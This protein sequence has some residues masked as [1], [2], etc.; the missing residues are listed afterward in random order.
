MHSN[1]APGHLEENEFKLRRWTELIMNSASVLNGKSG[2]QNCGYF[3]GERSLNPGWRNPNVAPNPNFHESFFQGPIR[4]VD[5]SMADLDKVVKAV[6]E[7]LGKLVS[8]LLIYDCGFMNPYLRLVD[9]NRRVAKMFIAK[10][11][12]CEVK[13]S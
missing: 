7:L 2:K 8:Q 1:N 10:V 11:E 3:D 4:H 9:A 12:T 13:I 6:S 5:K